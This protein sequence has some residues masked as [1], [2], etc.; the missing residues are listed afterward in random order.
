MVQIIIFVQALVDPVGQE[1]RNLFHL[2]KEE[3]ALT[4]IIKQ[5]AKK[6]LTLTDAPS[7]TNKK[8]KKSSV[9]IRKRTFGESL[10]HI[11]EKNEP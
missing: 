4:E 11:V 1:Q 5:K 9:S 2:T 8:F 3:T 7:P 6:L 10:I